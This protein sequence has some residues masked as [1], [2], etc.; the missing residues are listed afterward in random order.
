MHR[1]IAPLVSLLLIV[2][3]LV[4]GCSKQ[5]EQSALKVDGVVEAEEVDVAAKI[6]G[7]IQSVQVKE[8]DTVKAGQVLAYIEV[9]ELKEKEKQ[10]QA[11]LLK[12]EAGKIQDLIARN[13]VQMAEADLKRAEAA[14]AEV[15]SNLEEATIKAPS[16]GIIVTKYVEEGEMIAAGMPL[17]TIQQPGKNWVNVKVKETQVGQIKEGQKVKV[18]SPNFPGKT[19]DGQVESIRQK[20]DYATQRAAN[21]RGDKDIVAYNVKVRL[22]NPELKA[23]MSVTVDFQVPQ[24]E[25]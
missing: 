20:P 21:E 18:T 23:G 22:D 2:S 8:G 9:K 4:T 3:L 16:D 10:A 12:A 6:P 15:R 11:A 25:K 5:A 7:R 19:F 17:F 14:L 1:K 24:E 13:A